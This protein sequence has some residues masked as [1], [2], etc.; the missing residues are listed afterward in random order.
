MKAFVFPGQGA[1][2]PG[3]GKDLYE[4]YIEAKALFDEANQI[5]GFQITK[6]MFDGTE[7]DLLVVPFKKRKL[8]RAKKN[9]K[10]FM[11]HINLKKI[12]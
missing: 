3:M 2:Y 7:E 12:R 8:S 6:L 10:N 4:Q 11:E 5:L 1:Q 9:C